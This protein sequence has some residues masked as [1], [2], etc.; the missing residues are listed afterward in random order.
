MRVLITAAD[1]LLG[2]LLCRKLT[3]GHD[4][5]SIGLGSDADVAGYRAID[6]LQR[7]LVEEQLRGVDVV[8]HALPYAAALGEGEQPEQE[9]LDLVA[10]STYVLLT[11]ACAAQVR[12]VV[13][14]SKLDLLRAYDERFVV[15]TEWQP[16]PRA[17]AESLAPYMAELVGREV[18]RTGQIE[19][20]ALRFGELEVETTVDEAAAAV[21]QALDEEL[22]GSYHWIVKHI[23]STGRF[24]G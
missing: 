5:D 3:T 1:S 20:V 6:L 12:R 21:E 4:V 10:R 18:A 7:D 23:A 15:T 13:L 14:I 8:V 17:D 24:A 9:L 2:G 11:A 22:R 19:V 16:Q